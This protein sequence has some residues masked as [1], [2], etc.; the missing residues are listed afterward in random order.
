LCRQGTTTWVFGDTAALQAL[1]AT[2]IVELARH[3]A[4]A[5]W[6]VDASSADRCRIATLD[7]RQP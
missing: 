1:G 5:I 7:L 3:E 4:M 6:R 2:Q